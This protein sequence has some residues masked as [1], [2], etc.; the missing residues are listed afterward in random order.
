MVVVLKMFLDR[1][2]TWRTSCTSRMVGGQCS[3][4]RFSHSDKRT[5]IFQ[6]WFVRWKWNSI[7][8]KGITNS[9]MDSKTSMISIRA[10]RFSIFDRFASLDQIRFKLRWLIQLIFFFDQNFK[11]SK[12]N[13]QIFPK[14]T[15][16]HRFLEL[17]FKPNRLLFLFDCLSP[18]QK[19]LLL[20]IDPMTE[21]K[22][23]KILNPH[24]VHFVI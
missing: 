17:M 20:F 15:V 18:N 7:R 5:K 12:S 24:T 2:R 21:P 10:L 4:W 22:S 3:I 14:C 16:H 23:K 8:Q 19:N 6:I 1:W 9:Q 13:S 11:T